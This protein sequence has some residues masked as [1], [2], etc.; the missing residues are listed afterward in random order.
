[1]ATHDDNVPAVLAGAGYLC[2]RTWWVFLIGGLASV[3]FGILAFANPAAALFVI[4]MF[5]AAF[6]LVDG[7]ANIFGALQNRDQDGW[8]A[9][10][11]L[12]AVGVLVGGY[13]LAAPP[14]SM[15]ALIYVIAL[16]AMVNGA[17]SLYL[18]W[19]IREDISNEWILFASG[20]LSVLFAIFVL[21]RPGVGGVAIIYMIA[22]WAIVIG[23]MRIW[24]AFFIR[25]SVAAALQQ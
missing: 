20:A 14:V 10:L 23:L 18:G 5:F 16:F 13:A 1:M 21:F 4:A 22:T 15:V 12:G 3:G 25:K 8:I 7:A 2:K 6:I 9:V 11:L 19:K 24:F 17:L